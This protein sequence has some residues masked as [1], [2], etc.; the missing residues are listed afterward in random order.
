LAKSAHAAAS[1]FLIFPALFIAES[2]SKEQT[3]YYVR[4]KKGQNLKKLV[5]NPNPAGISN[6]SV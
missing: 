4:Y 5:G 3:V 6:S 1:S 2:W